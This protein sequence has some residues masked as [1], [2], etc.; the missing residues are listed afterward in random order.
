MKKKGF[1]LIELLAVILILAII[2]AILTPIVRNII[3]SSKEQADKR[4]AERY[5]RAAQEYYVEAEMDADKRANLGTNIIN[6]LDFSLHTNPIKIDTS[7]CSPPLSFPGT[8]LI[9]IVFPSFLYEKNLLN[10]SI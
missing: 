10:F 3:D 4:S 6:K 9:V 7:L 1:T 8:D 5:I 2:A